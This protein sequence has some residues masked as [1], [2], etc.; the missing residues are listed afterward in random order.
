MAK[1]K[2]KGDKSGARAGGKSGRIPK[3]IGGVKIP[4]TLRDSGKAALKLAQNPVAREMLAAGLVAAAGAVAGNERARKAAQQSGR[5]AADA[6]GNVADAA[7]TSAGKIGAALAEVAAAAAERFFGALNASQASVAPAGEASA[8]P[9][10]A[11][12]AGDEEPPAPPVMAAEPVRTARAMKPR[13]PAAP[14]A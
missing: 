13:P 5:E 4:K 14:A 8:A 11:A 3:E 2:T 10:E 9:G 12:P 7:G 1:N 6:L